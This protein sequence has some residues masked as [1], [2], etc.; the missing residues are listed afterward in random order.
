MLNLSRYK[1]ESIQ[2]GN[3]LLLTH[4]GILE[5]RSVVLEIR[6]G[7]IVKTYILA[8]DEM[9]H[10]EEDVWVKNF[11]CRRSY[12]ERIIL[13]FKAPASVDIVRTEIPADRR[14]HDCA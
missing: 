1:G 7:L 10:I 13:Q 4:L 9:L 8:I 2:V 12:G 3:D 14:R 11:R 6:R 5:G